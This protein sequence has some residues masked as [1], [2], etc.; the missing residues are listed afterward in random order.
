MSDSE[1]ITKVCTKCS[2]EF[3]AA[4]EFF[5]AHSGTRDKL[6]PRC[7]ECHRAAGRAYNAAN[8]E[9]K[10]AHNRAY[11]A[12]HRE[13]RKAYYA[14]HKEHDNEKSRQ[15]RLAHLEVAR[16][17]SRRQYEADC[18]AWKERSRRWREEHLEQAK[19]N[20]KRW[21]EAHPENIATISRNRKAR[22]LSADGSHTAEDIK[23][24]Y[25]RQKGKC[26]YCGE[27]VGTKYHVDHVI[28]L[29][30]GGSN[31][32]ENLVISC[33]TCN[34]SKGPKHPQDFCGRLL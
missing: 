12:A 23:A 7:K 3:P 30:S 25:E 27:R 6:H 5:Y 29:A 34:L 13:Q 17:R 9:A 33:P 14:A 11:D 28:P 1:S 19:A 15:W 26:Y 32:P 18:E 16:E 10:N 31:S 8:R 20:N 22:E 4:L 24:Q 21:A 2:R